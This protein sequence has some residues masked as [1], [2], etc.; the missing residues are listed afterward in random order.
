MLPKTA[1]SVFNATNIDYVLRNLGIEELV[2]T[3]VVT[4]QCVESAV[5]D[6]AD[7]S[8]LVTLVRDA[9][10]TYSAERHENAL[11]AVKGYCRIRS[12]AEVV[13]EIEATA[14]AAD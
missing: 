7:R 13:A 3:G 2:V 8:Y 11:A 4:D 14:T 12:T 6:A 10:C 1:S 5:R 9:C